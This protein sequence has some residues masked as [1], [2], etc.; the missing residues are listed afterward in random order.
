[1]LYK[2]VQG[3]WHGQNARFRRPARS[4]VKATEYSRARSQ[5]SDVKGKVAGASGELAPSSPS[6]REDPDRSL[7]SFQAGP[8]EQMPLL[9][10]AFPLQWQARP[11]G[12]LLRG[13]L[14]LLGKVLGR[15]GRHPGRPGLRRPN[16]GTWRPGTQRKRA[17]RMW[18]DLGN[19]GPL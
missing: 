16:R 2:V 7:P 15:R 19:S 9:W 6:G 4:T 14:G 12:S 17:N 13:S 5:G 10:V 1:M 11:V 3:A 8:A 18:N